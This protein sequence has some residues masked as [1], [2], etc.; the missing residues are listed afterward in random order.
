MA[1]PIGATYDSGMLIALE[2]GDRRAWAWHRAAAEEQRVPTVPAPCIAEVWRVGARQARLSIA[3]RGC[4]IE[5]L[6]ALTARRAGEAL[7]ATGRGDTIDACVMASAASRADL[8]L[9]D[10]PDDLRALHTAFPDVIV[11]ALH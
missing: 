11:V 4:R 1:T 2:R 7:A 5:D 3:L 6:D 10:D 8:V 9:T